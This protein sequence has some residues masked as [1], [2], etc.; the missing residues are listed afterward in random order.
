M[1]CVAC[2]LLSPSLLPCY[3]IPSNTPSPRLCRGGGGGTGTP[4]TILK[5]GSFLFCLLLLRSLPQREESWGDLSPQKQIK[6]RLPIFRFAAH[7]KK[8]LVLKKTPSELTVWGAGGYLS[9]PHGPPVKFTSFT[10]LHSQTT[11]AQF[12]RLRQAFCHATHTSKSG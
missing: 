3:I 4:F 2:P 1:Q 7:E 12:T 9:R 5:N 11:L 6:I 8:R 10:A